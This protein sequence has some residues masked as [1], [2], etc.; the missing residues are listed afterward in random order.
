[1]NLIDLA[2]I[3]LILALGYQGWRRGA[4]A[5]V[6]GVTGGLLAFVL[7]ALLAPLLA[8]SLTPLLGDRLG[9]PTLLIR[10]LIVVLLTLLLRFALGFAVREL[11]RTAGGM[12]RAVPPLAL[13]DR[14]L[15]VVPLALLGA[16]LGV[17]VVAGV[18]A[19]PAESGLRASAE[20]SWV[21]RN[22]ID[23]PDRTWRRGRDAFETLL[24]GR[25][26]A[27]G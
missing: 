25:L 24:G 1:M 26:P 27:R 13:L 8:P 21:T 18:R 14:T 15:G 7:A 23:E 22:V 5:V 9:V 19:L 11:A 20:R 3:A 4:V 12:I 6:L 16:L 10:P 2:V 17:A